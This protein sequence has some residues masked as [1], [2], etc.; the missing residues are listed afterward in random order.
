MSSLPFK[1]DLV[2]KEKINEATL[3]AYNVG[4]DQNK[5]RLQPLVDVIISVIPEFALGYHQGTAMPITE[6][7]PR[8]REAAKRVYTTD[9]Y[10]TRGEFGELILHLL[11]RDYCSS[12][13]LISKIYFK[14]TDNATVHGF[15]GV[16]IVNTASEKQLWLGES[17]LYNDGEAGVKELAKDLKKHLEADYLRRE[18]NLISTKLPDATPEIDH[19]RNLLHEHKKLEEVLDSI[20]IPMVCTYTSALFKKHNDNTVPYITDFISECQHLKAIFESKKIT[21]DVDV[22]L[23][24]LPVPSKVDLVKYLDE[25]LKHIQSI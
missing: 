24:L 3:R 19:W 18:F 14:D 7:I 5:F 9:N 13:P 16:H 6:V 11:L 2:F 23:M 21:T 20:C 4:F 22:L 15:D 12:I 8:L 1:S 17:K 25:R 10:E